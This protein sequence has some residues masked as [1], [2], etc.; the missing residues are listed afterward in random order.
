MLHGR[1]SLS[2]A[3]ASP[4]VGPLLLRGQGQPQQSPQSFPV[5][6]GCPP[7]S[8]P[9]DQGRDCSAPGAAGDPILDK[10]SQMLWRS[11][12]Q[13]GIF[14]AVSAPAFSVAPLFPESLPFHRCTDTGAVSPSHTGL[15][16]LCPRHSVPEVPVWER[17]FPVPVPQL[18]HA[19]LGSSTAALVCC[20][21][22]GVLQKPQH[23]WG[24]G[25]VAKMQ[26]TGHGWGQTSL[27]HLLL[28]PLFLHLSDG[29]E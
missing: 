24:G 14:R 16:H 18:L 5:K 2:R 22:Q 27:T 28:S 13:R 3:V 17:A 7:L 19:L 11:K 23:S 29:Q 25:L 26:Q 20:V 9:T 8:L 4:T 1:R 6:Q 10:D 21:G 15:L 12:G